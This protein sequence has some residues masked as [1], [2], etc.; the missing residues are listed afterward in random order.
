MGSDSMGLQPDFRVKEEINETFSP[1]IIELRFC[2][3]FLSA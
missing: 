3:T 1:Y 2:D